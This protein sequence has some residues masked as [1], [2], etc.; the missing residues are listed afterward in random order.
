MEPAKRR[1][2]GI[3]ILAVLSIATGVIY[4]LDGLRI[5]G[6]V[7]F[8]PAQAFSNV[9]ISGWST[10]FVG[11]LWIGLAVGFLSLRAWALL[12]GVIVVGLSLI[13]AFFSHLNG[14]DLGEL[15]MAT[16]LPLVVLFYLSSAKIQAAFGV[17]E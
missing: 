2:A 6:F 8:G 5:L 7:A 12:A 14:S 9:S 16:I 13:V 1:P 4:M 15:F 17:D 10:M 3:T 11:A